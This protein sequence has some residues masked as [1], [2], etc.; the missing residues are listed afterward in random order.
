MDHHLGAKDDSQMLSEVARGLSLQLKSACDSHCQS[1]LA[2]SYLGL[3]ATIFTRF[4]LGSFVKTK[5]TQ[6]KTAS[7]QLFLQIHHD[8]DCSKQLT[9]KQGDAYSQGGLSFVQMLAN[10]V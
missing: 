8:P 5:Q 4:L 1:L 7:L 6:K 2:S 10:I 9:G 3:Q